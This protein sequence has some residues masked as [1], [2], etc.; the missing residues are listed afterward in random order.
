M[1]RSDF[2]KLNARD[3]IRG[4]I[5]AT[6][7]AAFGVIYGAV[8]GDFDFTWAYWQPV[9]INALK[10]SIQAFMGYLMLNLFNDKEG[11]FKAN[12]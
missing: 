5:F 9:L 4:L 12:E 1:E 10:V 6:I 3:F 2:L 8:A 7:T 11:K